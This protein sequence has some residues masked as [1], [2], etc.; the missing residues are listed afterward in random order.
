M[1]GLKSICWLAVAMLPLATPAPSVGQPICD[2]LPAP[3]GPVIEVFPHQAH[4][5][6]SI[7]SS[8]SPGT[9]VLLH[10]GLYDMSSGDAISRLV[11]A[12]SGVTL[13]SAEGDREGVVL[14]GGYQTNELISIQA[15]NVTIADLTLRRAYDHPVHIN[16]TSG[17][18][19]VGVALH[20]LHIADPG[21]QAVKINAIDDGYA[22]HGVIE[23]S[24]IELTAAGRTQIRDN[25]YTGGIDA[26]AA[27][28]WWIRRNR[29]EGFWCP[30]GLSEH[31][32]HFWRA[33]RDTLVE[34]NVILDC[35]RGVGFGLGTQG[36]SRVYPDDPYPGV[37]DKGHIDG[38][39]RNNFIATSDASLQGS[40]SGFDVGIGLEQA[41]G[42]RVVHNS[43]AS[44]L[45][46]SS[47]SIEWRFSS[48]SAQVLNNLV[49]HN[50][51]QRD[52][53]QAVL[54]GNIGNAPPAWF[55][56]V[57]TGDLHLVGAMGGPIDAGS[58]LVPGVADLDIDGEARTGSPD[59]GAD[60]FGD[61]FADGF[62]TG[63]TI[64][65]SN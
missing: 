55:E 36:G 16:G 31:G 49:T 30:N 43:V 47:S 35:A 5:L 10:T 29:I 53:G 48:T 45:Q 17:N 12:V 7:V 65:W 46:P 60:E 14:D 57:A 23:C 51:K 54:D 9:T 64:A 3:M 44:S 39:V 38:I 52:G 24:H 61:L 34:E 56:N 22:D 62:E 1:S 37:E 19:I 27:F 2:P 33:S 26:H 18:P 42:A 50:L 58:H 32:V 13:R 15:S 20:N 6:R 11:F 40:A 25:C 59:V 21:Q 8:A 28:G 41:H 63:D 4:S